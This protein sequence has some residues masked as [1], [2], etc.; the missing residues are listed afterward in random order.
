MRKEKIK[1]ELIYVANWVLARKPLVFGVIIFVVIVATVVTREWTTLLWLSSMLAVLFLATLAQHIGG[2]FVL[3]AGMKFKDG[4]VPVA[5]KK[6][7]V[8]KKMM[9]TYRNWSL[10]FVRYD[11]VYDSAT[12]LTERI[13]F[14]ASDRKKTDSNVMVYFVGS[15][16]LKLP[17]GRFVKLIPNAK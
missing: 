4:A 7:K 13:R 5:I 2:R 6:E 17:D 10:K 3:R 8:G 12:Y 14:K 1:N 15:Q 16:T 11:S 9:L